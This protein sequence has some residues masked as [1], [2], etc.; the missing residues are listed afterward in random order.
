M[1]RQ[2]TRLGPI[3][4]ALAVGLFPQQSFAQEAAPAQA[5]PDDIGV[6][7]RGPIHEAFAGP[8][9]AA[10]QAG[11]VVP[12]QPPDP[13]PEQ[14]PDQKPAGDNVEWIPGNWAWDTDRQDFLWV[15]GT[16][17]VQPPDRKWVPG[18]WT[19]VGD[20]WQ[21]VSG[22]WAPAAQDQLQYQE[23]PPASLDNGPSAPAP[24]PDRV[25][26]PGCWV[27][28]SVRYV[29]QPGY[30]A[31]ARPGY[32][33]VPAHYS[34]TPS[35][36]V[37]VT[38]YWD[39]APAD[40]GL[41]F[42]PVC[43]NRP[44]WRNPNWCFRPSYVVDFPTALASLFVGPG[45][46]YYFGDYYGPAYSRL[47]FT[48]WFDW[49]RRHNDVLFSYYSR[50]HRG[51]PGWYR[52][53]YADYRARMSGSLARPP[54]TLVQQ[55]T[56]VR[57]TSLRVVRPLAQFRSSNIRL[58]RVNSTQLTRQRTVVNNF[59]R[60]S[61]RRSELERP[62]RSLVGR[63]GVSLAGV[64]SRRAVGVTSTVTGRR[65]VT[66]QQFRGSAYRATEGRNS[67]RPL[68]QQGIGRGSSARSVDHGV[69]RSQSAYRYS[70]YTGNRARS[71]AVR[72][73]H[74]S[75]VR[76]HPA[77]P[78]TRP[79]VE[80]RPAAPART[81]ARPAHVRAAPQRP[82]AARVNRPHAPAHAAAR[83]PARAAHPPAPRPQPHRAPAAPSHAAPGHAHKK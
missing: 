12:K 1:T 72:T 23:L 34:Y 71:E 2:L 58:T 11:P 25:Y 77:V 76:A 8:V 28:R 45:R 32:C 74:S 70:A 68:P 47:G 33:L 14:P 27:Y 6:Q 57:S 62:G 40:R 83:Q 79:R 50:Q 52:G 53:L 30:W 80:H 46:H 41:L 48:P 67:P 4:L 37:F 75:Q 59:R 61:V 21:W 10:A 82:A 26:V 7:A 55:N 16:W 24:N 36:C 15:S 66:S 29:W 18:Y 49:G 31:A 22:F 65:S 38:S 9:E 13:I 73:N 19:K 5:G 43:F 81:N 54:R 60:L 69:A 20:G 56:L 51:D 17:R 42:A 64:T 39:Y 3:L 44:L 35:G 63:S 78:V